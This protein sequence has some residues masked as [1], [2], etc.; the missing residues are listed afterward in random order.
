MAKRKSERATS[1]YAQTLPKGVTVS[2]LNGAPFH[3]NPLDVLRAWK[4]GG[5][6]TVVSRFPHLL[7]VLGRHPTE[8]E[9]LNY[10]AEITPN[11]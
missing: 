5:R 4:L 8:A 10:L 6:T 1:G 11:D 7:A 9:L 3:P 2:R